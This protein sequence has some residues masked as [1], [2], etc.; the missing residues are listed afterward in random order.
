[1][2]KPAN[3]RDRTISAPISPNRR[4]LETTHSM[5]ERSVIATIVQ[6]TV[7]HQAGFRTHCAIAAVVGR[8]ERARRDDIAVSIDELPRLLTTTPTGARRPGL[9][10]RPA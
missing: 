3:G 10:G 2:R 4:Q 6:T 8:A 1:M 9:R 7:A 5:R